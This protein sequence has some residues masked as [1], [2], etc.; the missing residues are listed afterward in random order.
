[1]KRQ[2]MGDIASSIYGLLDWTNL[3]ELDIEI[4]Y[5]KDPIVRMN[6][7]DIDFKW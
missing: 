1:M 3:W 5:D 6:V 7:G 2:M 4:L